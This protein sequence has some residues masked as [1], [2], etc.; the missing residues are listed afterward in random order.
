M[1][2]C[3][4]VILAGG[5]RWERILLFFFVFVMWCWRM[6]CED[7]MQWPL[8]A[9][10]G[11]E[12]RKELRH[13]SW[14]VRYL[15]CPFLA[16]FSIPSQPLS[17]C[18]SLLPCL[19]FLAFVYFDLLWLSR[20]IL[21][22]SLFNWFELAVNGLCWTEAFAQGLYSA[23]N[24]FI[25]VNAGRPLSMWKKIQFFFSYTCSTTAHSS[26]S[27]KNVSSPPSC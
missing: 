6:R 13:L 22:C 18:L 27:F 25:Y 8:Y 2:Y 5:W 7:V 23:C 3:S 4:T 10:L 24:N 11:G 1:S 21:V 19:L 20:G 15:S 16:C 9:F 17:L 26:C 14:R 12:A